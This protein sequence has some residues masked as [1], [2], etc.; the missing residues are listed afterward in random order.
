MEA[1]DP[2]YNPIAVEQARFSAFDGPAD[3]TWLSDT[4]QMP[5]MDIN[6]T[7]PTAGNTTFVPESNLLE[8]MWAENNGEVSKYTR[9]QETSSALVAMECYSSASYSIPENILWPSQLR[10]N[11]GN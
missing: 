4:F 2:W 3:T 10:C 9:D 1:M 11:R 5:N 8:P 6:G 7:K